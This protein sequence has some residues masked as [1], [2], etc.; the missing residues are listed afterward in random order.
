M[1]LFQ[2]CEEVEVEEM[3]IREEGRASILESYVKRIP[4]LA[5]VTVP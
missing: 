3:W 5:W 2:Y 1:S 4:E